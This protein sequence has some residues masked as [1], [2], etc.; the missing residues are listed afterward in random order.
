VYHVSQHLT[1]PNSRPS[2]KTA[3]FAIL[4]VLAAIGIYSGQ[5]F[6]ASR[7]ARHDRA[8]AVAPRSATDPAGIP[9][10]TRTPG[11]PLGQGAPMTPFWNRRS[12]PGWSRDSAPRW[13]PSPA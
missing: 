4:L 2:G 1:S 6:S 7:A 11:T 12:R 8:Y 3:A 10:S 5:T 9:E 13:S